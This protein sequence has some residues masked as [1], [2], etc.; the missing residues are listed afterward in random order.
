MN[1]DSYIKNIV[2][3]INSKRTKATGYLISGGTI[4]ERKSLTK[5]I[6]EHLYNNKEVH[7]EHIDM[8][9][10]LT[11]EIRIDELKRKITA[12]KKQAKVNGNVLLVLESFDAIGKDQRMGAVLKLIGCQSAGINLLISAEDPIVHLVGLSE[13]LIRL[14]PL[15]NTLT[16]VYRLNNQKVLF[17]LQVQDT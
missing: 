8:I 12:L 14:A 11:D 7:I 6:V 2:N 17:S 15:E 3:L 1:Y 10:L 9:K 5:D 16:D 13:F 4:K